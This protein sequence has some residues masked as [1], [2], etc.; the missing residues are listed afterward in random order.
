MKII[1]YIAILFFDLIDIYF[2]QK[3]ILKVLKKKLE[4]STYI[5]IGSHRGTY[6]DLIIKN[7]RVKKVFMFEPQIEIFKFIKK[8]YR[9]KKFVKIFHKA[10]SDKNGKSIF[11]INKH[12]LT[13]S[14][15]K[16]NESSLYLRLK[17]LL[18]SSIK[19]ENLSLIKNIRTISTLKLSNLFKATN[20]S[21]VS[22][23]KIDTEGHELEVLKGAGL[24]IK[25]VQCFL[26]EFHRDKIYANYN[27]IRIHNLLQKNGF[28]LNSVF[29]FPFTN[30][31]DR[32]Y[33]NKRFL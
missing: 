27:P 11:Y 8:K 31:E 16:L 1:K 24:N 25:K 4:I 30:W 26:I 28:I 13:S 9:K 20:L 33:F 12:D 18:F 14:L 17:A 22:L 32:I 21:K 29:K 3:K 10:V 19:K 15:K 2:H 7:F 6:T 23:I 5:D